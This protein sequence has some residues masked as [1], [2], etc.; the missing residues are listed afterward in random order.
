M[1]KS[2]MERDRA[3]VVTHDG[4][5]SP[6]PFDEAI[7]STAARIA[8]VFA[9]QTEGVRVSKRAGVSRVGPLQ[10]PANTSPV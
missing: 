4:R 1:T 3:V 10:N 5:Y 2:I 9:K 7:Q 8:S 6:K